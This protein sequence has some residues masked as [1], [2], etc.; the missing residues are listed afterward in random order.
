MRVWRVK[1]CRTGGFQPRPWGSNKQT[2]VPLLFVFPAPR[3]VLALACIAMCF[4]A[5]PRLKAPLHSLRRLPPCC[6]WAFDGSP[7]PAVSGR[8][9][10]YRP[11]DRRPTPLPPL[12]TAAISPQPPSLS[13]SP[14][15]KR[16][17]DL[18]SLHQAGMQRC[19]KRLLL[20]FLITAPF[21]VKPNPLDTMRLALHRSPERDKTVRMLIFNTPLFYLGYSVT[22][23]GVG[24]K[25]DV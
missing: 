6:V 19:E 7:G 9:R 21:S 1:S 4:F 17:P 25:C 12:I 10:V 23:S 22:G 14:R 5:Q 8:G 13:A 24:W 18:L 20:F 11:S 3:V 16:S 15:W 2:Y